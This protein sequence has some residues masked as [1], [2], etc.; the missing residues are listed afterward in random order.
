MPESNFLP[1]VNHLLK[2]ESGTLIPDDNGRGPSKWGIT[3]ETAKEL[4][5][6]TDQGQI[7]TL[8]RDDAVAFYKKY[9]WDAMNLSLIDN[10]ALASRLFNL[11]VNIGSVVVV[12]WLQRSINVHGVVVKDDGVLGP[13]T[14]AAAN[15]EDSAVLL[16]EVKTRAEVHYRYLVVLNPKKYAAD[17]PGWLN[18][19]R[20][21]DV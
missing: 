4:G 11:G 14:A 1:A 20:E 8:T 12:H 15:A 7:K 9:F 16:A 5:F 10:L 19:L 18:R 2:D 17:L 6:L 21:A 3:W 13:K